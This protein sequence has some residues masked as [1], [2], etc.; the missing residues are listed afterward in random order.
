VD[1]RSQA[2]MASPDRSNPYLAH[3]AGPWLYFV[4]PLDAA[5]RR[6]RSARRNRDA[7]P[8]IEL[9]A[10]SLHLRIQSGEARPFIGRPLKDRLDAI[11]AVPLAATAAASLTAEPIEWRE[12]GAEIWTASLLSFEGD[13]A[14]ADRLALGA[15]ARLPREIQAAVLGGSQR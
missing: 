1:A 2:L 5:D 14:A 8:W 10:P 9:A 6:F 4:G 11:R 15:I 13:N 12:R 3:R 7:N